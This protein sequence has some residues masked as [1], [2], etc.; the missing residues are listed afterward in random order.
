MPF[1]SKDFIC[2]LC[3]LLATGPQN[4]G[5]ITLYFFP[6]VQEPHWCPLFPVLW[7]DHFLQLEFTT[8]AYSSH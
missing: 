4:E 6:K 5:L 3:L 8:V 7:G 2:A 1:Q